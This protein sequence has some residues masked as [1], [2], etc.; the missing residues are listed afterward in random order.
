MDGRRKFMKKSL[1]VLSMVLLAAMLFVSCENKPKGY[2][3]TFDSTG[4]SAVSSQLVEKGGKAT[5]PANPTHTGWGLLRWSA[6]ENGT[7]AFD[8]ENSEITADITLYA[9]WQKSYN[10]GDKGPAG[11][12]IIYDVDADNESGDADNLKSA[13]CGWKYLET[14]TDYIGGNSAQYC[15]EATGSFGTGTAIGDGKRNT[16]ECLNGEKFPLAKLCADYS[17]ITDSGI[18]FDD[19]FLPSIEELKT[20]IS[21]GKMTLFLSFQYASSSEAA[22]N[23]YHLIY[24]SSSDSINDYTFAYSYASYAVPVRSF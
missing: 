11:G 12:Y 24:Y 13:D 6:T 9:V 14:N 1:I 2:T 15:T 7:E 16:E 18:T 19:W 5:V 23:K 20:A 21:S 22:G 8:F 17:V 4:G 3:V 10:V